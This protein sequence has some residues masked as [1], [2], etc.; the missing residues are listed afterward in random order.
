[1]LI[2]ISLHQEGHFYPNPNH[3]FN[4]QFPAQRTTRKY[5]SNNITFLHYHRDPSFE[6]LLNQLFKSSTTPN[7]RQPQWGAS[8]PGSEKSSAQGG[9]HDASATAAAAKKSRRKKKR[10]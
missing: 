1:M 10:H 5:F 9:T 7:G 8:H 6:E 3:V 2:D 4:V